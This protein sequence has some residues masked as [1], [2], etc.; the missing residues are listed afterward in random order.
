MMLGALDA[1]RQIPPIT[2][3]DPA[4]GLGEAYAVS[5]AVTT[6]RTAR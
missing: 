4:F 5:Q 1:R 2:D 6:M 3:S